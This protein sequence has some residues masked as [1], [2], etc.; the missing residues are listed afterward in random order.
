MS[1]HANGRCGWYV[2]CNQFSHSPGIAIRI[3]DDVTQERGEIARKADH[4]FIS[5]IR[6]AGLYDQVS[7]VTQTKTDAC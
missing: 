6:N 1:S 5:M 3:L 4:I 7:P 2:K